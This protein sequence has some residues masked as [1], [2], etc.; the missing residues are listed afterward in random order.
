MEQ[1]GSILTISGVA[2]E[3]GITGPAIHTRYPDLADRIRDLAEKEKEQD[4]KTQ[5]EK[6]RGRIKEEK[7]KQ[8]RLRMELADIKELLR[9]A[10]SVNAMLVFENERL[11]AL[12]SK[13][14]L[15][16]NRLKSPSDK[17]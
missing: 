16:L 7:A 2:K 13:Y 12:N 15:E 1:A 14:F 10:D 6:R 9:K 3:A 11:K 17:K 5:L 4:D 8:E